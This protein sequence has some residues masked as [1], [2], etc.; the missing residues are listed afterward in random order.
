M[1]NFEALLLAEKHYSLEKRVISPN[2]AYFTWAGS[3]VE[4]INTQPMEDDRIKTTQL[5]T[6]KSFVS[7][8]M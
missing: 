6:V 1:S 5:A 3:T 2:G 8:Y 4:S 7:F